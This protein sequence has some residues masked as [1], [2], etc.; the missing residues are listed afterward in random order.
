MM[1]TL[2]R[3]RRRI[4][5]TMEQMSWTY[6]CSMM[7]RGFDL[8]FKSIARSIKFFSRFGDQQRQLRQKCQLVSSTHLLTPVNLLEAGELVLARRTCSCTQ[9]I[10]RVLPLIYAV[11]RR[12]PNH[13]R[14]CTQCPEYRSLKPTSPDPRRRARPDGAIVAALEAA[15]VASPRGSKSFARPGATASFRR[16]PR[17]QARSGQDGKGAGNIGDGAGLRLWPERRTPGRRRRRFLIAVRRIVSSVRARL[18]CD[19]WLECELGG[20]L[21]DRLCGRGLAGAPGEIPPG[22]Q[23]GPFRSRWHA[24][25]ATTGLLVDERAQARSLRG[26]TLPTRVRSNAR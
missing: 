22:S 15:A 21:V 7:P 8:L 11:N 9:R 16:R 20:T 18:S 3:R 13:R 2:H 10:T 19:H 17:G 12:G 26:S 24:A 25:V 14:R 23:T 5:Q 1:T 4:S 6:I